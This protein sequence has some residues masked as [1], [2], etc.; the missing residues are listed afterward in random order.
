MLLIHRWRIVLY[1]VGEHGSTGMTPTNWT[2]SE[3]LYD[4]TD[5]A[6]QVTLNW[7]WFLL[8]PGDTG[9]IC[10]HSIVII[11]VGEKGHATGV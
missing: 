2:A 8:P 10:S 4:K 6:R 9:N 5:P 1:E 11:G 7:T 3:Y